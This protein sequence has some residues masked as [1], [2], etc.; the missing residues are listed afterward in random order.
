MPDQEAL[1]QGGQNGK[2]SA[3]PHG[4][5]VV[6]GDSPG[7]QSGSPASSPEAAWKYGILHNVDA[8]TSKAAKQVGIG[9]PWPVDWAIVNETRELV[10]ESK[11]QW[12]EDVVRPSQLSMAIDGCS[13]AC[14]ACVVAPIRVA[15]TLR[16]CTFSCKSVHG[17][18]ERES[19]S[20][21]AFEMNISLLLM[22]HAYEPVLV[23]L[24]DIRESYDLVSPLGTGGFAKVIKGKN[25]ETGQDVA[26]KHITVT[27]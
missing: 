23:R 15:C 27:K 9:M 20:T 18:V 17:Y 11:V 24:Q 10:R 12:H 6:A 8:I 1:T 4:Y 25:K 16:A 14:F 5:D 19:A 26:I 3:T 2:E 21:R 22:V 13:V 7:H